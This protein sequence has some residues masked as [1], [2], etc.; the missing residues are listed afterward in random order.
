[1]SRA[2][3]AKGTPFRRPERKLDHMNARTKWARPELVILVRSRPEE[4]VLTNCK[5]PG[6]GGGSADNGDMG[7]HYERTEPTGEQHW[8]PCNSVGSS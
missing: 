5:H 2:L 4:A 7:C 1:M 6:H 8:V 3:R